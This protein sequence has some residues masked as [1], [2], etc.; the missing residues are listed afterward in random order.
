[1]SKN[2]TLV[3][4]EEFHYDIVKPFMASFAIFTS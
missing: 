3:S 4:A 2:Y 1:M